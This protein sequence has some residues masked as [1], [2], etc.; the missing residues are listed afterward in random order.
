MDGRCT[1][2][3]VVY[4][5]IDTFLCV[6]CCHCSWCQRETGSAFVLNGLIETRCI[7]VTKG[8]PMEV[9]TP[10]A[11]RKGQRILRCPDCHVALWS[12]YAGAGTR[13]AFL[14][15]STLDRAAD[16]APDVHIFTLTKLPWIALPE[17]TPVFEEYYDRN[18]IWRSQ[19]VARREAEIARP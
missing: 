12:H 14:R 9:L 15:V 5:L 18:V 3:R 16:V 1:C 4:R 13:F 19:A 7:E 8:A 11:S 10:S 17:G 2:G 6:H